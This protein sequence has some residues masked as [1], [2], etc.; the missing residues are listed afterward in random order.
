MQDS[1]LSLCSEYTDLPQEDGLFIAD[2]AAGLPAIAE[3]SGD[4]IF[5]DCLCRDGNSAIVVAEARRTD[6]RSLYKEDVI[7]K[8]ALPE[9]EPGV[10]R[11]FATGYSCRE[12]RAVTQENVPVQQNIAPLKNRDGKIVAVLIRER[13][14]QD[15]LAKKRKFEEAA[16]TNQRLQE[17]LASIGR[18]EAP[19]VYSNHYLTVQLSE[20]SHRI[21]NNLQMV[22]S[23][24]NMEARRCSNTEAEAILNKN[25]ARI[26]TVASF[27]DMLSTLG[28]GSDVS[29]IPLLSRVIGSVKACLPADGCRVEFIISGSD[30]VVSA[31]L[32]SALMLVVNELLTNSVKHAFT[33]RDS[34]KVEIHLQNDPPFHSLVISDNGIGLGGDIKKH[35][36]LGL[37]IVEATVRDKIKGVF[38]ISSGLYGKS[39]VIARID[40]TA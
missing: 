38:S 20:M 34:G 40:F 29:V 39:G 3:I 10:F 8:L 30:L 1:I 14:I 36:S 24:M 11:A 13:N 2:Y 7:G 12:L 27:H 4:D 6:G 17:T 35:G 21:K 22:A 25:V 19:D 33:G 18:Q 5:L 32:A 23:I 15:Q 26:L 9:K 16:Q 37:S 31:D 28:A